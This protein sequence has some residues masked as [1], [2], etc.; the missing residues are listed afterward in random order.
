MYSTHCIF[1]NQYTNHA[2]PYV[3]RLN[4][5]IRFP[6]LNCNSSDTTQ[7]SFSHSQR[8]TFWPLYNHTFVA[9]EEAVVNN[10]LTSGA[11]KDAAISAR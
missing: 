6:Q 11:D 2:S 8:T 4:E 5:N 10:A 3:N 1:R 9:I 7:R